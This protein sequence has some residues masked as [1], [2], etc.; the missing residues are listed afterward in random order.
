[1]RSGH[2]A[3]KRPPAVQLW[4]A[5]IDYQ[6]RVGVIPKTI[7]TVQW[8]A[9]P[10]WRCDR[11]TSVLSVSSMSRTNS[12]YWDFESFR[13]GIVV[14]VEPDFSCDSSSDVVLKHLINRRVSAG[15][16][17]RIDCNRCRRKR[18]NKSLGP[19]CRSTARNTASSIHTESTPRWSQSLAST[20]WIVRTSA[21]QQPL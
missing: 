18:S 5:R 10:N 21:A 20:S 8:R 11:P 12:A 14:Y 16:A 6:G 17:M 9:A 4:V 2:A 1:M 13:C 7:S 19:R 15:H 3:E